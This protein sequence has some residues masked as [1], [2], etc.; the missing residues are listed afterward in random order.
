MNTLETLN[1]IS[2]Q[3]LNNNNI[4]ERKKINFS[5]KILRVRIYQIYKYS[6]I[7]KIKILLKELKKNLSALKISI[8]Y[9]VQILA[10]LG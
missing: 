7:I 6:I 9:K 8:K 4:S 1:L 10:K 3:V 5:K 2:N